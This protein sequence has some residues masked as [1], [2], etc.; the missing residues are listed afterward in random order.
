[1]LKHWNLLLLALAATLMLALVACGDDDDGGDDT[2][3]TS[4]RSAGDD[5]AT[6]G[7]TGD[8]DETPADDETPT[9][10]EAGGATPPDNNQDQCHLLTSE[11]VAETT[12]R[13]IHETVGT[14]GTCSFTLVNRTSVAIGVGDLGAD[15]E[16]LFNLSRENLNG[17][18]VT[19]LGD[20]AFWLSEFDQLYI[21]AGSQQVFVTAQYAEDTLDAKATAISLAEKILP[22]LDE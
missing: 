2:S 17:E 19:G 7:E 8:T 12:G 5:S 11:E 22:R 18:E 13:A 3:A 9:A 6:P 21:R 15:P 14:P 20:D 16:V 1:M 4:T 10:T